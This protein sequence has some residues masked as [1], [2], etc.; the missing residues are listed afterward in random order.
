MGFYDPEVI[1]GDA[2]RHGIKILSVDINR[3]MWQ[4]SIENKSL[5]IG[6]RYVKGIG[7]EKGAAVLKARQ[8]GAFTSLQDFTDKTCLDNLSLQNLIAVGAFG[9]L[10]QSRRQLLWEAGSMGAK[11]KGPSSRFSR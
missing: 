6:F 7:E 11:S 9:A 2:R 1:T 4:C 3:S 8:Q 10:L 5:R